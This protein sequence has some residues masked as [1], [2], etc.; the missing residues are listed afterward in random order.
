MYIDDENDIY[1]NSFTPY[2]IKKG[3]NYEMRFVTNVKKTKKD[4]LFIYLM[5]VDAYKSWIEEMK[6]N[7][8]EII[9]YEK[10]NY[11]KGK[12]SVTAD[13]TTLFTSIPYDDGWRVYVDGKKVKYDKLLTAFIGL[14]LTEGEH[15]IEFKYIPK[16]FI[17]GS[18]I[19]FISLIGTIFYIRK[20]K[21]AK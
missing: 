21:T 20:Q 13:K 2:L 19:S 11:I 15:I 1:Y 18:I 3:T 16:G 6:K 14:D 7:Q 4:K 12:I 5:D 9:E 17:I 10:D 8:L